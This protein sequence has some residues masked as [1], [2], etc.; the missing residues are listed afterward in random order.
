MT[1][2]DPERCSGAGRSHAFGVVRGLDRET[3]HSFS[4][5]RGVTLS[6]SCPG[7]VPGIRAKTWMHSN[8][9]LPSC[10]LNQDP[11][12]KHPAWGTKPGHDECEATPNNMSYGDAA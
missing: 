7:F 3:L 5:V 4:V 8:S 9:A 12:R 2:C 6:T 10:V 11:S 1:G